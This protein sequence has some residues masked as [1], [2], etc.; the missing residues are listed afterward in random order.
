MVQFQLCKFRDELYSSCASLRHKS[1]ECWC[2][3]F[4]PK[5]FYFKSK[6]SFFS[7]PSGEG[8]GRKTI[9]RIHFGVEG[10]ILPITD[11][12]I[13]KTADFLSTFDT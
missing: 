7:G 10:E 6:E 8:K 5:R 13:L 11:T 1:Q 9:F 12:S 3:D 2:E 4:K